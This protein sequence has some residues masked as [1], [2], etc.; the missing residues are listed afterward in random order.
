MDYAEALRWLYAAQ[1][2]GIKLGL[3]NIRWLIT[4]MRLRAQADPATLI[5]HVAGT[6]GKG[7]VCAMAAELLAA[8]GYRVGLYTSPH[9]VT[10][11]ERIRVAGKPI[12]ENDAARLITEV[13]DAVSDAPT[14]PTFFEMVTAMALR[15]FEAAG[16]D[17]W[18]LE[19]GMGGRFDATNAVLPSAC[20][21]TPIGLDHQKY[22][23]DTPEQIA[24]EKAGI[25]K[26]GIPC[27]SAP[28]S[29]PVRDVLARAA[30]DAAT[31]L[32]VVQG[33]SP[34]RI[35]LPGPHQRRNAAL[36][37]ALVRAAGVHP[38]PDAVRTALA[39]VCWPAR[40]QEFPGPLVVDGA[41][42]AHAGEALAA[43]WVERFADIRANVLAGMLSDK[44][45]SDFFRGLAPAIGSIVAVPVQSPRAMHPA[46]IAAQA[47]EALPG[48]PVSEAPSLK[49]ALAANRGTPA[50]VTGSLFLAGEALA[51]LD[52]NLHPDPPSAQ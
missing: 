25:I 13:R 36:A 4:R 17:A 30:L 47:R 31:S 46:Q 18:V 50:L 2:H 3:D 48:V 34:H 8:A 49:H 5:L 11:R 45:A 41:H 40:F 10:F 12:S 19:T 29:D 14:S 35:S 21:I 23:G 42:N 16:C 24:R 26:R 7:S 44:S 9:L 6:N 52:S 27:L 39:N 37:L 43:A 33:E 20:A 32:E 28:Q 15:H 38:E 1:P 22:L 51:I